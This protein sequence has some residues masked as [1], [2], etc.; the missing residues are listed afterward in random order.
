MGEWGKGVRGEY[1]KWVRRREEGGGSGGR[2]EGGEWGK[3][4][5]GEGG[6]G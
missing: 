1:R 4:V 3:G 5:R 2:A 6:E